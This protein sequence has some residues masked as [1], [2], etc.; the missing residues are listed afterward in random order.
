MTYRRLS[1]EDK[2]LN[3]DVDRLGECRVSSPM[4]GVKFVGEDKRHF[5]KRV[6]SRLHLNLPGPAIKFTTILPN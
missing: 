6:N 2:K 1:V 5:I 3:F 4:S